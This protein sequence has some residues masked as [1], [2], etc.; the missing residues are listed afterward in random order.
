MQWTNLSNEYYNKNQE[1]SMLTKYI[2]HNLFTFT[3]PTKIQI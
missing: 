3:W 2:D 1:V